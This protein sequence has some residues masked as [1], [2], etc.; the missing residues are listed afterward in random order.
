MDGVTNLLR[1]LAL[2]AAEIASAS[3][4]PAERVR[5]IMEGAPANLTELRAL[6]QGLRVPLRSFAAGQLTTGKQNDLG[7]L[8][9]SA[10][11][12]GRLD[13]RTTIEFV[14]GFVEAALQVLPARKHPPDWLQGFEPAAQT[15]SEAHRLA[16]G[17]RALFVPQRR[18]EAFLELPQ[19]LSRDAG[20]I[21][22]S[23]RLSRF[24]GASII[25]GGYCFIFVS[26]RFLARMLFTVAHE[27]GH[28][29]AHHKQG[30][31]VV[32]DGAARIGAWRQRTR[33]EQF[34][35]A[36]ASVL[37]MPERGIALALK[38]IRQALN[39]R[40]SNIGDIQLLY[41]ARIFGVSFDAVAQRCEQLELL[42][43]GGA[44][45]L[46]DALRKDHGNPERRAESLGL[47]PRP[48]VTIPKISD[49][50][51]RPLVSKIAA[52]EISIG[53]AADRFG[54]SID[55]FYEANVRLAREP[56]H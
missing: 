28:I 7:L 23:L 53:W 49:N 14:A 5:A 15:Y 27:L 2:T 3:R 20:I 45:S 29:L 37:L 10:A 16:H 47:P 19:A 42:P 4:L 48:R 51:L 1:S 24:E 11:S 41:L 25:I 35:D 46:S 9:R 18:D 40:S 38:A 30:K 13:Q 55:E 33:E 32:F 26:P 17:F 34:A 52:D 31:G 21:I 39:I 43:V 56:H 6:S 36:F 22:G 44:R 8:F 50:L 12:G 54:L